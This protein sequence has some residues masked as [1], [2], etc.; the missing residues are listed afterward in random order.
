MGI[1]PDN[2]GITHAT[3]DEPKEPKDNIVGE[4]L[5]Q[6]AQEVLEA[7]RSFA[8]RNPSRTHLDNAVNQNL[9]SA[10]NILAFTHL[11]LQHCHRHCPILYLPALQAQSTTVPLLLVLFLGGSL[12]SY[13]RDTF[14]LA[15]DCFDIAEEF[16][17]S[18]P[19][20]NPGQ[21]NSPS[22]EVEEHE[23]LKAGVILLHLQIGRNQ[24]GIL[25]RVR[26]QRFP[27]LVH[28]ARSR[29]FF[30]C[31]RHDESPRSAWKPRA[32][33]KE[34]MIRTAAFILLLDSQFVVCLRSPPMITIAESKADL[35]C[36][37]LLFANYH[38]S[39]C[40]NIPRSPSVPEV[41]D[42]LMNG[43]WDG[44][45]HPALNNLGVFG[46]FTVIAGLHVVIFSAFASRMMQVQLPSLD[47]ALSRWKLLWE[48]LMSRISTEE[49]E[50]AGFMN[51][52][53]EIWLIAKVLLRT[54]SDEFFSGIESRSWQAFNRLLRRVGEVAD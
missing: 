29:S 35:P 11:Y 39:S 38:S 16:L 2:Q 51:R 17:F 23:A 34:S 47:R 43:A 7:L 52:A 45:S 12:H 50:L 40:A 30:C 54:D 4:T 6:R 32:C 33:Q 22:S 21:R 28:A 3:P 18:L 25:Q 1:E 44:P 36:N 13:P 20:F 37:E 49:M 5:T 19:V 24:P 53:N 41:I 42:L 9:F 14:D 26:Y 48:R 31:R 8:T 27:M 46:L 10:E 15:V